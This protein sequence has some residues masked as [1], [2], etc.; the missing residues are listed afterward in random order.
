MKL[1]KAQQQALK[2]VWLRG[3][4]QTYIQFRRGV[5][6]GSGCIMVHWCNMWLGI[7]PDGYTH[8]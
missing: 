1:T 2:R 4:D 3:S 6:M 7:E 8:S 5:A